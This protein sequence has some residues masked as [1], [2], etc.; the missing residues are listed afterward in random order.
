MQS[1]LVLQAVGCGLLAV[2]A[3]VWGLSSTSVGGPP[4]RL[5]ILGPSPNEQA[6]GEQLRQQFGGGPDMPVDPRAFPQLNPMTGLIPTYWEGKS[7]L[8]PTQIEAQTIPVQQSPYDGRPAVTDLHPVERFLNG[9]IQSLT[10]RYLPTA[11]LRTIADGSKGAEVVERPTPVRV[12]GK[13]RVATVP[14]STSRSRQM[15]T[16]TSQE[17]IPQQK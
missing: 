16:K 2:S 8:I 11:P 1:R 4:V 10:P 15:A 5:A 7:Q 3:W 12:T 13:S 6:L 17:A 9:Q 14:R